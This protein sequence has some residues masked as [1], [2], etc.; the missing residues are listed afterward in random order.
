[1][2]GS[3][4][5][6]S[7]WGLGRRV[8]G[9]ATTDPHTGAGDVPTVPFRACV[10]SALF[11]WHVV[12]LSVMQLRHYLFIGTL[13]PLLQHLAHGDTH[14]GTHVRGHGH[15]DTRPGTRDPGETRWG[16]G[17]WLQGHPPG[18]TQWGD[19]TRGV[20]SRLSTHGQ[21]HENTHVGTHG[22]GE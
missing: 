22:W 1:M 10:C 8:Q 16:C 2:G 4:Q 9:G 15:G 6:S 13:N 19:T 20:D 3:D 5:G 17:T 18:Y 11:A 12:W 14:L 7:G 21:C